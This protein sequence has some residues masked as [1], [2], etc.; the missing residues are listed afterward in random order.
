MVIR[1]EDKNPIG[2]DHFVVHC[3]RD[4][5]RVLASPRILQAMRRM[6]TREHLLRMLDG[7]LPYARTTLQRARSDDWQ[8]DPKKREARALELRAAL[9]RW[10]S[11]EIPQEIT[12]AAR[13][14]LHADDIDDVEEGWEENEFQLEFPPDDYLLWPEG[15]PI[16]LREKA[17]EK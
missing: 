15:I 9:E 5:L 3:F 17:E 10:T 6:P 4:W 14:L 1:D 11:P 13:A 2:Y 12:Q 8:P 16:K 7:F